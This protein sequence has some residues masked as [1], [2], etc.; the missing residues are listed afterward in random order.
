MQKPVKEPIQMFKYT[1]EL[2][3]MANIGL[4]IPFRGH[5]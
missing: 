3:I 2:M 4:I 5:S 1:L